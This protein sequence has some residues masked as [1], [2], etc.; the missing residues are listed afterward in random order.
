MCRR[1][2]AFATFLFSAWVQ[3]EGMLYAKNE[4][5]I[6]FSVNVRTYFRKEV[7]ES[8][9]ARMYAP[10]RRKS[11]VPVVDETKSKRRGNRSR[12]LLSLHR[13]DESIDSNGV[14]GGRCL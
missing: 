1:R 9:N 3:G 2:E 14:C 12:K 8:G 13:I 6:L 7:T 4:I 10:I 11:C 5:A